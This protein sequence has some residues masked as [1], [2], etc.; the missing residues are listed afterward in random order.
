MANNVLPSTRKKVLENI[1][2]IATLKVPKR[3]KGFGTIIAYP[4]FN[5]INF[6][7]P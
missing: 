5:F 7:N 3:A 6:R 1:L 2:S 4:F